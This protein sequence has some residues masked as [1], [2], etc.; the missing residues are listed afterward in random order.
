MDILIEVIFFHFLA[1]FS[2]LCMAKKDDISCLSLKK[3]F[4]MLAENKTTINYRH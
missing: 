4:I 1:D 2:V 3:S